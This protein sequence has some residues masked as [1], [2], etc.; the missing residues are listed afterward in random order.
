ML[1][2]NYRV[3]R[4]RPRLCVVVQALRL[5]PEKV[6][7]LVGFDLVGQGRLVYVVRHERWKPLEVLFC[8]QLVQQLRVVL[9]ALVLLVE[10]AGGEVEAVLKAVV[11][12]MVHQN[13][14]P[15]GLTRP[16]TA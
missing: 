10:L 1:R 15:V 2:V 14:I 7:V 6:V 12:W 11:F 8:R 16:V 4:R 13:C 3:N 9:R 5:L